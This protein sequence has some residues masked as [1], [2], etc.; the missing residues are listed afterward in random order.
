MSSEPKFRRGRKA[1]R[2]LMFE[3]LEMRRVFDG[4]LADAVATSFEEPVAATVFVEVAPDDKSFSDAST[5]ELSV[6][7]DDTV[8]STN[9]VSEDTAANEKAVS[10]EDVVAGEVKYYL[11]TLE[12]SAD[13]VEESA[14]KLDAVSTDD[15][16]LIP[17]RYTM[18]GAADDGITS[19]DTRSAEGGSEEG[20]IYTLF[21]AAEDSLP[22]T[23]ESRDDTSESDPEIRTLESG[24]ELDDTGE[25]QTTSFSP[26]VAFRAEFVNAQGEVITSV[27]AGENF[28]M[29]V[30][31]Q[32]LRETAHGVY[33]AYVD[34][35]FPQSLVRSG[36]G[37]E[38]G[39]A[40]SNG[41]SGQV[42]GGLVDELGGFAG[43]TPVG[44][45]EKLVASVSLIARHA[46]TAEVSLASATGFGN[47]VLLY[48]SN[49]PV[50]SSLITYQGASLQITA[51]WQ[52]SV[53]ANDVDG[54]GVVAPLDV[55]LCVN[56]INANGNQAL[57]RERFLS[58]QSA[59]SPPLYFDVNGDGGLTP[60]DTIIII[61]ELNGMTPAP[62]SGNTSIAPG[63]LYGDDSQSDAIVLDDTDNGRLAAPLDDSEAVDA[64]LDDVTSDARLAPSGFLIA[65]DDTP[66]AEDSAD[67]AARVNPEWSDAALDDDLLSDIEKP[68][69]DEEL[70]EA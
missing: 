63:E 13:P 4:G 21:E 19:E 62:A 12:V 35:T 29:N 9:A 61:N 30:Y 15:G 2:G 16:E 68:L 17:V 70:L 53:L 26:Q 47:D 50:D 66:A 20:V 36:S 67:A 59:E 57:T 69:F 49:D 58:L 8:Y 52:N 27:D 45:S 32:D 10:E 51:T 33:A 5:E 6:R 28:R 11:R 1:R 54:D 64:A 3:S 7:K 24:G 65:I 39:D 56:E 31:V 23:L 37:I 22:D 34:A 41:H 14:V 40:Y 55:L 18:A 46:G 25:V 44:A 48:G 38:Y 43:I 42:I 60:L